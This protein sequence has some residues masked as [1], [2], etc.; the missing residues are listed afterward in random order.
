[1]VSCWGIVQ[2]EVRQLAKQCR[3]R[4]DL[5]IIVQMVTKVKES[6]RTPHSVLSASSG[7][8]AEAR[9]AGK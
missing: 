3:N 8:I 6:I 5:R 7:S 9:R 4:V 1:M 2:P